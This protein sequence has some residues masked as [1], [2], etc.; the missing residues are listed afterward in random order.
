[1]TMDQCPC[2]STQCCRQL[3]G[4]SP[5]E[6]LPTLNLRFLAQCGDTALHSHPEDREGQDAWE[7]DILS[8]RASC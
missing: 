7:G 2:D 1:M 5:G 3:Y 6:I 4:L 8:L